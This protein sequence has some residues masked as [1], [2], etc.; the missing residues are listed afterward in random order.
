LFTFD[1][2][3]CVHSGNVHN[4]VQAARSLASGVECGVLT[5]AEVLDLDAV[6]REL[7]VRGHGHPP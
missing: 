5:G 3:R 1:G 6:W 7:L 2:R 4:G